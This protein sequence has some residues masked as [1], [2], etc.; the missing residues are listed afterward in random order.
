MVQITGE[1]SMAS[2]AKYVVQKGML[3][4]SREKSHRG[5]V[6]SKLT[7]KT[8]VMGPAGTLP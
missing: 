6:T 5:P 8:M 1:D 7:R 3:K 4:E 2:G